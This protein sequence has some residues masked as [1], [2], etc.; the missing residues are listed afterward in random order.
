MCV[1][2]ALFCI[3]T[4]HRPHLFRFP[5]KLH[6]TLP[7]KLS[8]NQD[9]LNK[10]AQVSNSPTAKASLFPTATHISQVSVAN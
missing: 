1:H 8:E 6:H 9:L 7:N 5:V 2:I 10:R 3:N 4:T